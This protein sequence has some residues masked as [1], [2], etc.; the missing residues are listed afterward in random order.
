MKQE[1]EKGMRASAAEK[2]LSLIHIFPTARKRVVEE[3]RPAL[4]SVVTKEASSCP[5]MPARVIDVYKRQI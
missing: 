1:T 4:A 5:M 3:S 2:R